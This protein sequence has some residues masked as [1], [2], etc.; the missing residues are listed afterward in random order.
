MQRVA[1][2]ILYLGSDGSS[3]F[4]H[5][6]LILHEFDYWWDYYYGPSGPARA[7]LLSPAATAALFSGVLKLS[8]M[9]YRKAG[10]SGLLD[11]RFEADDLEGCGF[12]DDNRSRRPQNPPH[13]NQLLPLP[14]LGNLI[15][16]L[17]PHQRIHPHPERLLNP[18][19]HLP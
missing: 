2:G 11:F 15:S 18:Q 12:L 6:G 3:E 14:R 7:K 17:H 16:R 19:R 13:P 8:L 5:Q 4:Q 9:I 10:Y 1:E